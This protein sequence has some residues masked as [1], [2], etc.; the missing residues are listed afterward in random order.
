L[1]YRLSGR[2]S[3]QPPILLQ[4]DDGVL[5]AEGETKG[6]SHVELS[7]RLLSLCILSLDC[8]QRMPIQV[9]T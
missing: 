2:L 8:I 6:M 5:S 9:T 7:P 1:G 3:Y 4:F